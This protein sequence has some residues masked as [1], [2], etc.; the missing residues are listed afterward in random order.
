[1][2]HSVDF[3][4]YIRLLPEKIVLWS[5]FIVCGEYAKKESGVLQAPNAGLF[6]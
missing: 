2:I 6:R 4:K 3:E 5:R 1:M